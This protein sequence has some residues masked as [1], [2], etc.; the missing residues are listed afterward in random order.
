MKILFVRP[1]PSPETI[2]LQHMMIVEPLELEILSALKRPEDKS[3]LADLII[4]R[5]S[6]K[7]FLT[8]IKPDVLC[9]TG[10]ITHVGIIVDYCRTAKKIYPDISTVVGGVHC[11]VC[12]EDFDD[13]TVDFRVVRNPAIVFTQLL[14]FIAKETDLPRGVLTPGMIMTENMLPAFDFRIPFPDRSITERHRHKYFYIFYNK[15][16]LIKTS[17]GCPYSCTFCFCRVITRNGY[18]QRPMEEVIQE[19]T[20]IKEENVYIVDDDFLTDRK[21]LDLF[22]SELRRNSINKHFLVYGRADFIA[23]NPDLIRELKSVGLDTVIVG[24]ESFSEK[25]LEEYNKKTTL[26]E[27]KKAMAVLNEN[28]I[29]CYATIIL[30]PDWGGDDFERMV[31]EV[32]G[33]GIHY[34]NLQPLTPLPKTGISYPEDNLL[35]KRNE[36]EKWDLAHVSVKPAQMSVSDYYSHILKA[37]YEILFRREVVWSHF[38]RYRLRMLWKML[39]GSQKVTRQYKKKLREEH[40]HA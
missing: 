10:Y 15:V 24:F 26:E 23:H 32:K 36:W 27:S 25:E 13:P 21:R 22:V 11:E 6:L 39:L 9:I 2:G 14:C 29:D 19:L 17:F 34:V 33:L 1:R 18:W 16:A 3:F 7:Y 28:H 30:S 37:Y 35:I 38:R 12:P 4:E 20:L 5:K 40:D 31:S 8:L